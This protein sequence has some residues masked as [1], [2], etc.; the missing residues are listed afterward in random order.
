MRREAE[1]KMWGEVLEKSP[2]EADAK[3]RGEAVEGSRKEA[4]EERKAKAESAQ[5]SFA[6]CQSFSNQ[7]TLLSTLVYSRIK[8]WC[9]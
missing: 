8:G 3:A 4:E 2:K 6:A 5:V 9:V 1:E 7:K